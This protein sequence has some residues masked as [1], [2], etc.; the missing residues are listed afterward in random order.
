M[1]S[2]QMLLLKKGYRVLY[3]RWQRLRSEIRRRKFMN[4]AR[5]Q[6]GTV[7]LSDGVTFE[8]AVRF[9]GGGRVHLGTGVALGYSL[10]GSLN[11]P[12]IL[13][14]RG[15]EAQI[16]IG[17]RSAIMNGC[18]IVARDLIDI[19]EACLV[20]SDVIIIDSHFHRSQPDRRLSADDPAPV[21]LESNVWVGSRAMIL[22]GVVVHKDA[23]VGAGSVV[24]RDVPA[25][26]IVAGNP[27]RIVGSAYRNEEEGDEPRQRL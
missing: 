24:T 14:P 11:A 25:G 21:I 10:A 4:E 2:P 13:Q 7:V 23:I 17:D 19:G 1:P 27:A 8:H 20:G 22:K 5:L 18:Y 16:R 26:A 6:G 9:Q 3:K 12:I 15:A